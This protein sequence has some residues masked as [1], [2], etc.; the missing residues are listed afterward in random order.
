MSTFPDNPNE[1]EPP[2]EMTVALEIQAYKLAAQAR[3]GAAVR[4]MSK[5]ARAEPGNVE[6]WLQIAHWQRQNN[7]LRAAIRTLSTALRLNAPRAKIRGASH[8]PGQE[9]TPP[10]SG[11]A[12]HMVTLWQALAEAQLEAQ[13]WEECIR[14]CQA[15]LQLAPHHHCTQ[16]ILATALLH[17]G[18]IEAAEHVMRNLLLRS[19]RD[20]LHRLK[21]ATLLQ[22]Q[23]RLGEAL[24]EFERVLD[25]DASQP[26]APE[27]YEAIEAL[28]KMQI[29]QI[30]L[31]AS[32]QTTFRLYLERD[33][34]AALQDVGFYLSESG[35]EALRH[36]VGEGHWDDD[37]SVAPPR[38]H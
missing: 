9:L 34:D 20:P 5:V 14:A 10:D 33:F 30:L 32:E 26:L 2:D 11:P 16:E 36:M 23:G 8:R 22:L 1:H 24:R 29:Q 3:W 17:S 38:I 6:R 31:R 28:D 21:L 13:A 35:R 4:A 27:A 25:T 7:D 19:P 15:S 12:A 37:F 18:Q